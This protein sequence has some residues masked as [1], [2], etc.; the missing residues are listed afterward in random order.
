MKTVEQSHLMIRSELRTCS[1]TRKSMLSVVLAIISGCSL[2]N[3][4][5]LTSGNGNGNGGTSSLLGSGGQLGSGGTSSVVPS[6]SSSVGGS[7]PGVSGAG[8]AIVPSSCPTYSAPE[9]RLLTPPSNSFETST[10][11]WALVSWATTPISMVTDASACVGNSY[12]RCDGA[13]RTDVWDGP[14][15]NLLP[16]IT[17]GHKYVVSLA[18]RF[19]PGLGPTDT[20]G[21]IVVLGLMCNDTSV[22]SAYN[23]LVESTPVGYQWMRFTGVPFT[24][25]GLAGCSS[26]MKALVYLETTAKQYSIDIDDF[27]VYD[28]TPASAGAGGASS[29]GGAS[30]AGGSASAG[31]VSASGGVPAIG[32][33]NSG[34]SAGDAGS[35]RDSGI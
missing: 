4:D 30:N 28:V 1:N 19:S 12:L 23:H 5:D 31:G 33:M 13:A 34:S 2:Q 25:T 7:A 26:L 35:L 18:T 11:G 3:F 14:S 6:S 21:I 29:I 10:S 27:Q 16:Y 15:F 9:G 8:G 17:E 22:S 24:F 32:G 20:S